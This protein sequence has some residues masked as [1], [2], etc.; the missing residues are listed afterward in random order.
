MITELAEEK[1]TGKV[2]NQLSLDMKSIWLPLIWNRESYN[3][4]IN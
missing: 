3:D 1:E 2:I 4:R